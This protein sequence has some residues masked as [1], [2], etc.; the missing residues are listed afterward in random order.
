MANSKPSGKLAEFFRKIHHKKMRSK[1][2]FGPS[3]TSQNKSS[4]EKE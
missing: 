2:I 3:L 1:Y 4:K